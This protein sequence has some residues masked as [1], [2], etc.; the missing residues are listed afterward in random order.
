M[1]F[2]DQDTIDR[3]NKEL[4]NKISGYNSIQKQFII[5]YS[6]F[7]YET[8]TKQWTLHNLLDIGKECVRT[9]KRL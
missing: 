3:M 1:E 8:Y 7:E 2:L 6:Y 9:I 5:Q 4:D